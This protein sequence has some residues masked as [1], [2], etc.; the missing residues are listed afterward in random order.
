MSDHDEPTSEPS[1]DDPSFDEIRRLLAEAR[2]DEPVP[3]DV[4]ARLDATL[5]GLRE[6]RLAP[7]VPLRHRLGRVLVAAAAV[8]AIG[9]GGIGIAQLD[10]DAGSADRTSSAD[11]AAGGAE[12]GD[13][14]VTGAAPEVAGSKALDLLGKAA[15]R[16]SSAHFAADAARTMRALAV[17]DTKG[18]VD[19]S[20]ATPSAGTATQTPDQDS[21]TSG[22]PSAAQLRAPAVTGT[23]APLERHEAALTQSL[24][25]C[26][27]P[28]APQAV[29][30]P[31][32]LDGALVALVFRPPTAVGQ[33]VEAWSCDGGS[34]LASA[35][36]PH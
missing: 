27:G 19:G 12:T 13:D 16:L 26:P 33:V 2:T 7:V 17:H 29:T 14:S 20:A 15:P 1:F 31:A 3:D 5:A 11:K 8:V 6:E 35:S 36:I 28:V 23:P 10:R 9:A 24:A 18:T 22:P 34:L 4:A 21:P 25:T 32:T 30:V